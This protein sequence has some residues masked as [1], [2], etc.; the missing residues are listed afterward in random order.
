[1]DVR[2]DELGGPYP[3]DRRQ[4]V[5]AA[6]LEGDEIVFTDQRFGC[7]SHPSFIERLR[8]MPY[9]VAQERTRLRA[10][11]NRIAVGL[12]FRVDARIPAAGH[13]FDRSDADV[14]GF[15]T[16]IEGAQ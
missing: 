8:H 9:D 16:R 4:N 6:S 1:M 13:L 7:A 10:V 15:Q 3:P 12:A 14:A 5:A 2:L 11:P